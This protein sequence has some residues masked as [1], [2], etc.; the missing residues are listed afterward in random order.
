MTRERLQ[1]LSME[2]LVALARSDGCELSEPADR[3]TLIESILE[4]FEEQKRERQLENNSFVRVEEAKFEVSSEHQT[5]H[6]GADLFPVPRRYN[7]TRITFLARDPHWAFAFWELDDHDV[8]RVKKSDPEKVVLRV[9]DVEL[10]DRD[11]SGS[12]FSFD[13]PVR[14]EDSSWYIYLPNHDCSYSVEVGMVSSGRFTCLAR[15]NSIRTP[16]EAP[17]AAGAAGGRRGEA[18]GVFFDLL[19]DLTPFGEYSSSEAIPQ[20]ILTELKD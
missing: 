13:I 9:H 1:M 5:P 12:G 17:A 7:Q 2:E 8:L 11:G 3:S 16:R 15:S 14:L 10:Q 20:R 6:S 4:V 19:W 18:G